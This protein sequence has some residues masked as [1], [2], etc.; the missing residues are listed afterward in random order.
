MR[1]V[2]A[3]LLLCVATGARAASFDCAKASTPDEQAICADPRLSDLDSLS[4]HAFGEA[5]RSAG[6]DRAREVT[7]AARSLLKDRAGCG[8]DRAC[9]TLNY[10]TA[11]QTWSSYAIDVTIPDWINARIIAGNRPLIP[12]E[13]F[14]IGQC[15]STRIKQVAPRLETG[16]PPKPGDFDMG[17]AVEYANGMFGVSYS[18]EPALLTSRPG[19]PV[20]MCLVWVPSN[21]PPG[22]NRGRTYLTTNT[23]T[24]QTWTLPDSQHMCG[25]A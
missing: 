22:D 15:A 2:L 23:R 13:F 21:C 12:G 20:L 3:L 4:A 1:F 25:G 16:Q 5:K 17:T 8:A 7:A 11:L 19:D 9:I 18:R 10:V 6:G 24:G 14:H